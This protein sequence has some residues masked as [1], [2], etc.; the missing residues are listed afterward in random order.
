MKKFKQIVNNFDS[1]NSK[2]VTLS[3][4]DLRFPTLK[5]EELNLFA[6]ECINYIMELYTLR[7]EM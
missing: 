2:Q 7:F 3:I 5:N 6:T 1:F 4:L